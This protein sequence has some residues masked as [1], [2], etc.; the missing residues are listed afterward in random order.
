MPSPRPLTDVSLDKRGRKVHRLTSYRAHSVAELIVDYMAELSPAELR[1]AR[2]LRADY[3]S[4]GLSS[5]AVLAKKSS[6]SAPTVIR[7]ANRLG[8]DGFP[9]LRAS[10]REELSLRTSSPLSRVRSPHDAEDTRSVIHEGIEVRAELVKSVLRSVPASELDRAIAALSN[11]KHTAMFTGGKFS[12]LA[13]RYLQLQ[14]RHVRP[15]VYFL[16]DPLRLDAGYLLDATS[17]DL[18]VIFDFR[19]YEENALEVARRAK[20]K[21]CSV[22]LFTDVWLSPVSSLADIVIPLEVT[23]S[24]FD[25]LSGLFAV[26]ESLV[27]PVVSRLGETAIVR[28]ANLEA[29]MATTTVIDEAQ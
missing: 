24:F 1:I 15:K 7:F 28:M 11:P 17:N 27:P 5:A 18:L 2:S 8:F 10:L 26:V 20:R 14:L 12:H 21:G 25:S 22:L 13:A 23:A 9:G 6:T 19:R 29:L 4:A 16:S 3:P